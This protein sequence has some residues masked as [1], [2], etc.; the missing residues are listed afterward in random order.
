MNSNDISQA[1]AR[2]L[3]R[4]GFSRFEPRAA[5]I[6]M[7]GTLYDSMPRHVQAWG[8]L[9]RSIGIDLTDQ[10]ILLNEGR[11]GSD[12][13]DLLFRKYFNR[14]ATDDEKTGLYQRKTE[15]FASMPEVLPMPG[16]AEMLKEFEGADIKRVLVTG[17]GQNS[18][19]GRLDSDFPGAFSSELRITAHNVTH[20][21]PAPDP[22]LEAMKLVGAEPWQSIV[23]ENAPLGVESGVAAK[24][25]TIAVN[26]GNLPDETLLTPG[27]DLLFSSMT[28]CAAWL[29][30][31][32]KETC[33][34]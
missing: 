12:T 5:L 21:K 17:S 3:R 13:I 19:I 32:I 34:N 31:L 2:Y 10:E 22:Y 16:A 6:D 33:R 4:T 15:L 18:L 25:F 20:G 9:M 28:E 23:V 8:K 11:T 29:P 24:A 27:A 26:T 1:I 14:C 30:T 7:D